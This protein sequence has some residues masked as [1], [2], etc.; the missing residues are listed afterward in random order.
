MK[1]SQISKAQIIRHVIQIAAYIAIPELFIRTLNAVKDIYQAILGGSFSIATQGRSLLL[2][3]AI[4]PITIIFGRFFCGYLCAFGSMQELLAFIA[5]KLKI[6]QLTISKETDSILKKGKYAVL[7]LL[8]A[9][10]TLKISLDTLSPWTVFGHYSALKNWTTFSYLF[11]FGGLLLVLIITA[12]LFSER[13][14]CKYFCPVGGIFTLVSGSRFFKIK[15]SRSSCVSCGRCSVRCPMNIDVNSET[16][17]HFRVSSAECIDC[18]RCTAVCPAGVLSTNGHEALSGSLAAAAIAGVYFGGTISIPS[19]VGTPI[20]QTAENIPQGKYTDGI[21]H[22]SGRGYHGNVEVEVT[23]ENGNITDIE[24]E[25]FADDPQFFNQAKTGVIKAILSEQS[26]YV[27]TVSGATFSSC[28]IIAAVENALSIDQIIYSDT[29]EAMVTEILSRSADETE[30]AV[31]AHAEPEIIIPTNVPVKTAE[32]KTRDNGY[33]DGTYHG[34]GRGRNGNIQVSVVV[35][36]GKITDID[37]ESYVDDA[38]YF[39]R[40][41]SVIDRVLSQ[42]SVDVQTVSGATMSS[43]GILEAVAD[44]LDLNFSNPNSSTQFGHGGGHGSGKGRRQR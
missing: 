18:F 20:P 7:V 10:W 14:F 41:V 25:S 21:Y 44:A 32:E 37:V 16:D 33:P 15:K 34:T 30:K 23:V 35:S 12:S 3:A 2:L 38:P 40:A 42:Q 36:G 4:L 17:R 39:S 29:T 19:A 22:G 31:A 11:T 28:G 43:N 5:K 9:A 26:T 1:T 24:I 6:K 8:T 13:I 27:R